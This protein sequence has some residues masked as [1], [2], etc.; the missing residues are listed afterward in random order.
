MAT[1]I[2]PHN[3]VQFIIQDPAETHFLQ[4]TFSYDLEWMTIVGPPLCSNGTI[5]AEIAKGSQ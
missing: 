1:V 5:L 3:N 4:D 2:L